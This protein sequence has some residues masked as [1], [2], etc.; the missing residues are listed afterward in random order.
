MIVLVI[1]VGVV[2]LLVAG[3]ALVVRQRMP[4]GF[5][6]IYNEHWPP[7]MVAQL[8]SECREHGLH[9]CGCPFDREAYEECVAE[10]W[11]FREAE[12]ARLRLRE[13]E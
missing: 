12:R 13:S 10:A 7:D 2:A 1:V 4:P 11:K 5:A 9:G 3:G 8:C 6:E